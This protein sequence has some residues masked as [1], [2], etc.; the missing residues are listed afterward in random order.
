[1][2]CSSPF[3]DMHECRE[4]EEETDMP[5]GMG[6]ETMRLAFHC[7]S[8]DEWAD[9]LRAPLLVAVVQGQL[10]SVRKLLGAGAS[11]VLEDGG[12]RTGP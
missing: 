3:A 1:M 2:N 7:T 5:T 8:R 9:W 4:K 11:S 12:Y 6:E 10:S